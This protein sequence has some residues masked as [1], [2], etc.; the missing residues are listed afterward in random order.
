MRRLAFFLALK[1][2]IALENDTLIF[3]CGVPCFRA[4]PCPATFAFYAACENAPAAVA[5]V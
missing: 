4:E 1:F 5:V 3:A 2:A